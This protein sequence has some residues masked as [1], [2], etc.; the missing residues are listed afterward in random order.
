M[1]SP[2]SLLLQLLGLYCLSAVW[3]AAAAGGYGGMYGSVYPRGPGG[4]GGPAAAA[5]AGPAAAGA[6]AAGAVGAAGGAL[7]S[8]VTP[9]VLLPRSR[10]DAALCRSEHTVADLTGGEWLDLKW[11]TIEVMCRR[12][13][14]S[15]VFFLK[16]YPRFSW[17][18]VKS[19]ASAVRRF[20]G[21]VDMKTA[22]VPLRAACECD[23]KIFA[24]FYAEVFK[25]EQYLVGAMLQSAPRRLYE[26]FGE[27][28]PCEPPH[29]WSSGAIPGLAGSG[30][31]SSNTARPFEFQEIRH[32]FW[33]IELP[34]V[35]RVFASGNE[36]MVALPGSSDPTAAAGFPSAAAAVGAETP[37]AMGQQGHITLT[38]PP[39]CHMR[40]VSQELRV[41]VR[42]GAAAAA[43]AAGTAAAGAA[44]F[45]QPEPM[46]GQGLVEVYLE[47]SPSSAAAHDAL[48]YH[49]MNTV[50]EYE[51]AI[52]RAATAAAAAAA[53]TATAAAAA[54]AAREQQLLQQQREQQLLQ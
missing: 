18:P 5:A 11:G 38:L 9:S 1:M 25:K 3:T 45:V 15:I 54:A 35:P 17:N 49:R 23:N 51:L 12:S 48:Y 20:A 53:T 24:P 32:C 4:M 39:A 13:S 36:I 31:F 28:T 16:N 22:S 37:E 33:K 29:L 52:E 46:T 40:E 42:G 19:V 7:G 41:W 34:Y 2:P 21:S 10:R 47:V 30:V 27:R 50:G 43:A 6:A 26:F 44:G 8:C 14:Q